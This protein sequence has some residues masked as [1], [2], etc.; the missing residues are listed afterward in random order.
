MGA[1]KLLPRRLH[2]A[3]VQMLGV[4]PCPVHIEGVTDSGIVNQIG[5]LLADTRANGIEAVADFSRP[6]DHNV[7]WQ[8]G[9]EGIGQ[10][11][12]RDGGFG[13]EVGQIDSGVY[14]GIGSAA[15]GHVYPVTQQLPGGGLQCARHRGQLLLHLPAVV[16]CAQIGEVDGNIAHSL[17]LYSPRVFNVITAANSKSPKASVTKSR[18]A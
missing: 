17:L 15:T 1:H 2:N 3:L 11:L 6:G 4:K 5:I 7:R 13:A 10:P 16:G 12:Y 8:M 9:I 14:P 18:R